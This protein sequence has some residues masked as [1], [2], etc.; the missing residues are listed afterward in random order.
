MTITELKRVQSIEDLKNLGIGRV[1]Y[2][3]SYRGGYV[4]FYSSDIASA[5]GVQSYQMADKFGAYC[6]YLG[7]GVRGSICASTFSST[8][9]GNK[10]KLLRAIADACVR[11]YQ[12]IED[13][14]NLNDDEDEDGEIN[15]DAKATKKT[16]NW[17]FIMGCVVNAT[18]SIIFGDFYAA[19][20]W[21]IATGFI[22]NNLT[23]RSQLAKSLVPIDISNN[24]DTTI[25][26]R[27]R[28]AIKHFFTKYEDFGECNY[29]QL[30]DLQIH[31]I[32]TNETNDK[33]EV[34]ITLERPGLII[35]KAGST[36]DA[37]TAHL[38]TELKKDV[39]INVKES[40]LWNKLY[41]IK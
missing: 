29:K 15:W 4:G 24:Y 38:K 6:N 32:G 41:T 27:V 33:I 16:F 39:K 10:A 17:I 12:N 25:S 40:E 11:V 2:D 9:E 19:A 36:I 3:I 18:C 21:A 28:I 35:G 22:L 20:G 5:I 34:I 26:K 13:E 1:N 30:Y 31:A 14:N 37:L 7:G 23:M 8:V